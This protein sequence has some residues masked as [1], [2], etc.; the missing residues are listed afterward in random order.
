MN[1]KK[2]TLKE[3]EKL[4]GHKIQLVDKKIIPVEDVPVGD[5]FMFCGVEFVV[6]NN[7]GDGVEVIT[8]RLHGESVFDSAT[9]NYCTS[10][11]SSKCDMFHQNL[12][13]HPEYHQESKNT[14]SFKTFDLDLTTMDGHAYGRKDN[15]NVSLIPFDKY[16]QFVKIL[17]KHRVN[18]PWALATAVSPKDNGNEF[19][20]C[21]D[22]KTNTIS[23]MH[24]GATF[25]IRP[26]MIMRGDV[27][28]E[29]VD[30]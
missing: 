18:R 9:N 3:I 8:R 24:L 17:D 22:N 28:V 20:C 1:A 2:M 15:C 19:V 25:G 11:V 13:V 16:R 30:D 14:P 23:Q 4:L 10:I 27:I 12:M 21:W 6:L 29:A 26:Y 7:T 5:V